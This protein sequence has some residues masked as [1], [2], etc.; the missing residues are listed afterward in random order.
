V[1]ANIPGAS[2]QVP[3]RLDAFGKEI[4]RPKGQGGLGAINPFN[5]SEEAPDPV[6]AELARLQSAGFRVQPGFAGGTVNFKDIP[7][8]LE[9]GEK[10]DY[11][12]ISGQLAYMMLLTL[13]DDPDYV[14]LSDDKKAETIEGIMSKARKFTREQFM[15][16]LLPR[17]AEEWVK[18]GMPGASGTSSVGAASPTVPSTR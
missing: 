15:P 2:S 5:P 10:H 8:K 4:Q 9:R 12:A 6:D 14:R 11:Q 18:K 1:L 3:A 7:V 17:A 13:V 16:Q